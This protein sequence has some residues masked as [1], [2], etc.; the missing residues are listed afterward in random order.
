ML[1]RYLAQFRSYKNKNKSIKQSAYKI[2]SK[3]EVENYAAF[4][5][6]GTG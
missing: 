1:A 4:K 2:L 6:I 3:P 5:Y